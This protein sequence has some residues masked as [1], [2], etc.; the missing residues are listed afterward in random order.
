MSAAVANGMSV[1]ADA[2]SKA[3]ISTIPISP[4]SITPVTVTSGLSAMITDEEL[5]RSMMKTWWTAE[6][7]SVSKGFGLAQLRSTTSKV[8]KACLGNSADEDGSFHCL[9]VHFYAKHI[10]VTTELDIQAILDDENVREM[11]IRESLI[12]SSLTAK[13]VEAMKNV[14][15]RKESRGGMW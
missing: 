7:A 4:A 6:I 9:F 8:V 13:Q 15:Y 12:A 1:Y 3:Y 10:Q 14:S 2:R 11:V 5:Q